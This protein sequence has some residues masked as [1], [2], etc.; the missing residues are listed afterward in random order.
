VLVDIGGVFN[1]IEGNF[2]QIIVCTERL[3]RK[4]F[5]LPRRAGLP[6]DIVYPLV[7]DIAG[8]HEKMV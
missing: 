4:L 2:H 5:T 3:R 1:R 6:E 8:Q 7:I